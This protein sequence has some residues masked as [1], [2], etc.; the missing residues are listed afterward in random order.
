MAASLFGGSA[1][2]AKAMYEEVRSDAS[3]T[4]W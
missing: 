2:E 4:S 3:E 1:D